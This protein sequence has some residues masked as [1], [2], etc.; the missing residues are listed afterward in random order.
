[1]VAAI[2]ARATT[3][4]GMRL[5]V[6]GWRLQGPRTGI[7]RYLA[8]VISRWSGEA[9]GGRFDAITVY[10][11]RPV[12]RDHVHLPAGVTERVAGPPARMLVWDNVRFGLTAADDVL[13]C[14][15]YTRPLVVRGAT[16]VAIHDV[17]PLMRPELFGRSQ[18]L[19]YNRLYGWS[20][21]RAT[22]VLT[23]TEVA[24]EDMCREWALSPDRIRVVPLAAADSLD[25]SLDEG[26]AAAARERLVGSS[27]PYFLFVGK[28]AGRRR[29][30]ALV[31]AFAA[32]RD[33]SGLPHRLVMAGP[34]PTAEVSEAIDRFGL[35]REVLHSGFV[36]DDELTALYTGADGLV[37]PSTH[38]TVS[39]P[40]MEAQATGCPVICLDSPGT[41]EITNGAA[42]FLERLDV[43]SLVSAMVRLAR[44]GHHRR[45]LSD[46]GRASARRFSW[47][48]TAVETLAVLAEAGEVGSGQVSRES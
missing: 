2:E 15:S 30:P 25:R 12:D 46:A 27:V 35:D 16:V 39:L 4:G 32:F 7:W 29:V 45:E 37:C 22:L 17:I 31:E 1:M 6:D 36:S 11:P 3:T 23:S 9:V 44:D 42:L 26:S 34:A 20:A 33:A 13:F 28:T 21:R 38:E 40:I 48:R 24:R 43:E 47:D 10:T 19:F 41:R 8:N 14:P 18:R 5:G